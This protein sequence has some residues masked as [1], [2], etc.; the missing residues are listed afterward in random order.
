MRCSVLASTTSPER[1]AARLRKLGEHCG[2][3]VVAKLERDL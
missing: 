1:I 2:A 3:K